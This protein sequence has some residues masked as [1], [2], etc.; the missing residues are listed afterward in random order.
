[1]NHHSSA[2]TD[3]ASIAR[4]PLLTAR[5]KAE[6]LLRMRAAV[7]GALENDL[8]VGLSPGEIDAA[9]DELRQE[10]EEGRG[11]ETGMAPVPGRT[12]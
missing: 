12:H 7:T 4:H 2:A 5:E 3:P 9:M 11:S 10:I 6:L 1:M 8:E